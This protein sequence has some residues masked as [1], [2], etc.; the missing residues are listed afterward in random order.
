[1]AIAVPKQ[2]RSEE[3]LSRFLDATERLL[4]ERWFDDLSV[5]EICQ[6][7]ERS[8]GAFYARFGNKEQLLQELDERHLQEILDVAEQ[9]TNETLPSCTTL[10]E[11]VFATVE[12]LYAIYGSRPGLTRT[13]ILRSRIRPDE[14]ISARQRAARSIIPGVLEH[15]LRFKDEIASAA[16]MEALEASFLYTAYATREAILWD[17]TGRSE[18]VGRDELL[19]QLAHQMWSALTTPAQPTSRR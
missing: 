12:A 9:L 19:R 3:S 13:L 15:L 6:S 10:D 14:R 17:A 16:P 11:A 8:V 7:A 18:R 2:H 4:E 1:M 5:T